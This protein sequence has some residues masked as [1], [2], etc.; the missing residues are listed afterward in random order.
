[1]TARLGVIGGYLGSGKSTLVNRLLTRA[2]LGRTAV[3][4]NDFGS[5]NIDA[6]L[7]ASADGDTLELTNG[8]ICCQAT[9]DTARVMTALAA[10]EDLDHVLCEVSGV[11]D[12]GQLASWRSFPGLRPGPIVVCADA[13][14]VGALL[15]DQYVGD[16]VRRQLASAEVV[17]V[18]KTDLAGPV[19]VD[20]TLAVC[21][22]VAPAAEV[23][24]Q[25]A[26]H[27]EAT[28]AQ[29][30]AGTLAT[31]GAGPSAPGEHGSGADHHADTHRSLTLTAHGPVDLVGLRGGLAQEA[32]RL[33]R[34]KGVLQGSDGAWSEIHLAGERVEVSPRAVGRPAPTSASLVLIAAGPDAQAALEQART[35]LLPLLT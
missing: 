18:T 15:R 32:R 17:L 4:V 3:V 25:S 8:C 35:A 5:V 22:E 13:T 19:E 21:R 24:L 31:S 26:T 10:R 30:F 20:D 6:D 1:M 12:P 14:R 28:A 9:D 2:T 11:G 23:V 34:A 7:I 27:P 16:T 29:V 33:V